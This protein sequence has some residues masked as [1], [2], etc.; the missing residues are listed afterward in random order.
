MTETRTIKATWHEQV[1]YDWLCD[2]GDKD[3]AIHEGGTRSGKTYNIC[4]AWTEYLL[5]NPEWLSVVRATGPALKATVRRDMIEVL[6]AFGVYSD[7]LHNKTDDVIRLPGGASIEFFA[8]ED[9]M[10]V[11]GR[12][13]D[14]L[15]ANEANEISK[16]VWDQML[17]RTRLLKMLDFNPSMREDHWIWT[18]YD[19]DPAVIRWRSTYKDNPFLTAEQI[20]AI[21]SMRDTD[22][23]KWQVY[24]LGVRGVPADTIY[25]DVHALEEWPEDLD[26]VYGLD[27]GYT[28]PM[29][30]Q[31]IA[32]KDAEPKP[33]LYS[34][35]L[36][37]ESYLRRNDLIDRMKEA[38][39]EK[40]VPIYCDHDPELIAELRDAGYWAKP[41]DKGKGSVS[42]R[43]DFVGRHKI[44]VGGPAGDRARAEYKAYKWK[45]VRGVIQPAPAHDDSHAPDAGGYAAYS[46]YKTDSSPLHIVETT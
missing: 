26:Y 5:E 33:H 43:I 10:K 1:T 7:D 24:G 23:W 6:R 45:K 34:W 28:D 16:D 38:G 12:K 9:D 30:L 19:D 44:C 31:R 46:H 17:F 3:T 13:R 29:S 11:H 35:A 37:H 8:T 18:K 25:R 39:V 21:E 27:V 15:W 2:P 20:R 32:I 36:I 40:D 22:D 14:H 41:A 4:I 42:A